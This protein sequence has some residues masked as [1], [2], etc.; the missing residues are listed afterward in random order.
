VRGL[1]DPFLAHADTSG[2]DWKNGPPTTQ[3]SHFEWVTESLATCLDGLPV[4]NL[5]EAALIA[6]RD[7]LEQN[8]KPR[9]TIASPSAS[10]LVG[11]WPVVDGADRLSGRRA[12]RRRLHHCLRPATAAGA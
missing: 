11:Q 7:V 4:C 6:W 9:H 1:L 5:T 12:K 10:S 2:R 8:R 3:R